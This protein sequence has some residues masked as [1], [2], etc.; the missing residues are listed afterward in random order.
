[1]QIQSLDCAVL[2]STQTKLFLTC[3][4]VVGLQSNVVTTEAN[5][6]GW[7]GDYISL[8]VQEIWSPQELKNP[9][10]ILQQ[11]DCLYKAGPPFCKV[12]AVR[13]Q[14]DNVL[15]VAYINHQGGTRSQ[16]TLILA[17]LKKCKT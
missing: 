5:L 12:L 6:I 14:H 2:L 13:V 15:A 7:D 10:N 9:I 3:W 1:M 4:I 11:S 8:T 17:L 16:A